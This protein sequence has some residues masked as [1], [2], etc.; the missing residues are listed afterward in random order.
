M[1]LIWSWIDALARAVIRLIGRISPKLGG[2]CEKLWNNTELVTYLFAGV[3]TTLVNYVVYFVA[4]RLLSL[5]TLPGTWVA[6]VVAVAFGYAVNKAFVFHTHCD[7]VPALLREAGS[8]FAMR[9]VS[10][11]LETVLMY[12]TVEM[13]HFNDLVM[14]LVVNIV[15]IIVN[16]VFSKMVI[17]KKK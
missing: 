14:K 1:K 13:L 3:A 2:I 16:Y 5:D 15:V 4:T 12:I 9:L 8:F 10:L 7:G 6:W 17:F 11:G